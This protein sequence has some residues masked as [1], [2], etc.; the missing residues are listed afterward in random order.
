[1]NEVIKYIQLP[2]RFDYKAM[3]KEA[4][5]LGSIWLPH[6]NK[7]D[8]SGEW[9]AIPLRSINGETKQAYAHSSGVFKNTSLLDKCPAIETALSNIECEKSSV[10]ILNLKPGAE[11]KPHKDPGLAYEEGE[12]R[13][14]IP[15]QTNKQVD[16]FV[17]DELLRL[18]EGECWYINFNLKHWL[19]N[20]GE[21][22]R[23]HLVIDCK[24][25]DWVHQLFA[26]CGDSVI[27]RISNSEA[28]T[29]EEL[30]RMIV[31]LEHI[32]TPTAN[33]LVAQNKLKLQ[34]LRS[35]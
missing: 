14:H 24:V 19:F 35:Q 28:F 8:Y 2:L 11:I 12:I 27:K 13:I 6:Y 9:S 10:R 3:L 5:E 20:R 26:K 15:L 1:M 22:D 21:T 32:N 30:E 16:F 31:E 33:E 18:K 4:L 25:N 7:N 17:D 29:V 34:N 23:V